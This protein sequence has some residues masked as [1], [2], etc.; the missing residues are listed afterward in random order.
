MSWEDGFWFVVVCWAVMASLFVML[1]RSHRRVERERELVR[2]DRDQTRESWELLQVA[3]GSLRSANDEQAETI[4][5]LEAKALE[6]CTI[7]LSREEQI[8]S[9]QGMVAKAEETSLYWMELADKRAAE[10]EQAKAHPHS[11]P[12]PVA[13]SRATAEAEAFRHSLREIGKLVNGCGVE[14]PG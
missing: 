8:N 12:D 10:L 4:R 3:N 6:D 13:L 2:W 11:D 9:L 14:S 1:F 5:Q 7:L